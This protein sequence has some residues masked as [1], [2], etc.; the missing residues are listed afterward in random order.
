MIKYWTGIGIFYL[1]LKIEEQNYSAINALL[2]HSQ[3]GATNMKHEVKFV[4]INCKNLNIVIEFL[5]SETCRGLKM[6]SKNFRLILVINH[7]IK[8][9]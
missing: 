9:C 4:S 3:Q 7:M 2:Q 1:Y 8:Q 6:N 5:L